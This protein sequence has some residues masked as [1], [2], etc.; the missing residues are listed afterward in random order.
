MD[1]LVSVTPLHTGNK[2][3]AGVFWTKADCYGY[4]AQIVSQRPPFGC[5]GSGVGSLTVGG[6]KSLNGTVF[7]IE[8]VGCA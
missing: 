8:L 2:T 7:N 5:Q 1:D 3:S 4:F 6:T